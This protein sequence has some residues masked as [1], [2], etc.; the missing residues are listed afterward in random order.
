MS[1]I[2]R[3]SNICG[4]WCIPFQ[5][6]SDPL[7]CPNATLGAFVYLGLDVLKRLESAGT[8]GKNQESHVG[9]CS[10]SVHVHIC[11][12]MFMLLTHIFCGRGK[13]QRICSPWVSE[14]SFTLFGIELEVFVLYHVTFFITSRF[15]NGLDGERGGRVLKLFGCCEGREAHVADLWLSREIK[16]TATW[17]NLWFVCSTRRP[18]LWSYFSNFDFPAF[19]VLPQF[20]YSTCSVWSSLHDLTSALR[21]G[22]EGVLLY[23]LWFQWAIERYL[24]EKVMDDEQ[25]IIDS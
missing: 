13:A 2:L 14:Q 19:L 1:C 25:S 12:Y 10:R 6:D 15:L 11:R 9:P 4:A 20:G 16:A 23:A 21:G 5:V 18:P 17:D 22:R 8:H 24:A 7:C 3:V